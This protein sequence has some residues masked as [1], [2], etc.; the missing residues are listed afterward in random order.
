MIVFISKYT[1]I[2]IFER[3]SYY[4]FTVHYYD[5]NISY[6]NDVIKFFSVSICNT[7]SYNGFGERTERNQSPKYLGSQKNNDIWTQLHRRNFKN[8][9][10]PALITTLKPVILNTTGKKRFMKKSI[11]FEMKISSTLDL[12]TMNM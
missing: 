9:M 3:L 12:F 10:N 1:L 11:F 2:L 7:I 5:M 6:A 4:S 8:S